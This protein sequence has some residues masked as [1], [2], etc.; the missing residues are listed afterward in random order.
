M[1]KACRNDKLRTRIIIAYYNILNVC[2][3][4]CFSLIIE[5]KTGRNYYIK[6]LIELL[7]QPA[8]MLNLQYQQDQR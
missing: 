4:H 6:K 1:H 3:L 8:D 5:L 7:Q 2:H